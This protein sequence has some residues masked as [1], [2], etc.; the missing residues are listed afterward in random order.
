MEVRG[1]RR[2]PASDTFLLCTT[3]EVC[4]ERCQL[5]LPVEHAWMEKRGKLID[6]EKR[7]TFRP[8]R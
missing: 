5:Q 6:E 2:L 7:M 1:F 4:S 3:C 8:S